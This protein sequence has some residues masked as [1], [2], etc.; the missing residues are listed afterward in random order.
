MSRA[1]QAARRKCADCPA[2]FDGYRNRRVRCKD[3]V[4]AKSL[5]YNRI[6]RRTRGGL[7]G[8]NCIDCRQTFDA[9]GGAQLRCADCQ[10]KAVEALKAASLARRFPD[11]KPM[12]LKRHCT[13]CRCEFQPTSGRQF[14]CGNCKVIAGKKRACVYQKKLR[15]TLKTVDALAAQLV[16]AA[17]RVR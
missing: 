13:D 11:R 16:D 12:S 1:K 4:Y 7:E 3:C 8:R 10:L 15:E 9:L 2:F 17:Q 5:H 14:R 6:K